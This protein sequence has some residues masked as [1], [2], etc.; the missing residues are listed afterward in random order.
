MF[1]L[2]GY[3]HRVAVVYIYVGAQLVTFTAVAEQCGGLYCVTLA[4]W[5]GRIANSALRDGVLGWRVV[6]GSM[7]G[8]PSVSCLY[9]VPYCLGHPHSFQASEVHYIS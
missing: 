8:H 2:E 6:G 7:A 1:G 4:L 9:L 3:Q 5:G